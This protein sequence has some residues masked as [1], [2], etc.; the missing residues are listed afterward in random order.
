MAKE[1]GAMNE[2]L[3]KQLEEILERTSE[4]GRDFVEIAYEAWKACERFKNIPEN[5]SMYITAFLEG[6]K[7]FFGIKNM[8]EALLLAFNFGRVYQKR[9]GKI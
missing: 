1:G 7:D 2:E 3:K 5:E 8:R 9:R 6:A 4:D